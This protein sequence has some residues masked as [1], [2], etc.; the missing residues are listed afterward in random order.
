MKQ[1]KRTK[2]QKQ[3]KKER[4]VVSKNEDRRSIA[5]TVGWMLSFL[6]TALAELVAIAVQ[7]FTVFFQ[8]SDTIRLLADWLLFTAVVSGIV[9]LLLTPVTLQVREVRPP[10]LIIT[11]AVVV[12]ASPLL[13]LACRIMAA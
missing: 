1:K 13:V 5:I 6:A 10:Q 12:G 2:R 8:A 11:L 7:G 4:Q 9:T 3:R